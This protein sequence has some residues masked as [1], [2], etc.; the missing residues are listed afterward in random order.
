M[1][2]REIILVNKENKVADEGKKLVG[3]KSKVLNKYTLIKDRHCQIT[4][5][6]K[7]QGQKYKN[8]K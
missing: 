2:E 5:T 6:W 7:S 1:T 3:R 8:V 4:K